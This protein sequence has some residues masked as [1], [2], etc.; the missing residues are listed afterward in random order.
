MIHFTPEQI[1][2]ERNAIIQAQ[3]EHDKKYSHIEVDILIRAEIQYKSLAR[4]DRY[5]HF[6][7]WQFCDELAKRDDKIEMLER[8]S[9]E[10][11]KWISG[12]VVLLVAYFLFLS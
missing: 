12:A 2:E 1:A 7:L 6:E 3:I 5:S 9:R 11:W 8:Q 10:L 4:F